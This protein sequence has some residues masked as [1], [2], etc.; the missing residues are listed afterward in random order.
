LGPY[1]PKGFHGRP[2]TIAVAGRGG[3]S[4]PA[5]RGM[6][7]AEAA[8][9]ALQCAGGAATKR[10]PTRSPVPGVHARINWSMSAMPV[11]SRRRLGSGDM[12][13]TV[14]P[15]VTMRNAA[16]LTCRGPSAGV[17]AG[18]GLDG[19]TVGD[20]PVPL[21]V[22]CVPTGCHETKVSDAFLRLIHVR[23]S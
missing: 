7:E 4:P 9:E 20:R 1:S 15:C 6:A 5:R 16:A 2:P 11:Q 22:L 10:G 19:A 8:A 12:P 13:G 14:T 17:S 18:L 21:T 23:D 3:S